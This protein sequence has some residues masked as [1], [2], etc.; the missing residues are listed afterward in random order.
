MNPK[1]VLNKIKTAL[2][3]E[4]KLEAAKLDN[5]TM[6]EAEVFEAGAEIFI[7]TAEDRV[8]LPVGEYVFE[9]G[10][11]LVVAEE[12]IIGEIKEAAAEEEMPVEEAPELEAAPT[13][14]KKVV[15]SVSKEMFFSDDQKKQIQEMFLEFKAELLK[16]LKPKE[17]L[18]K[19]VELEEVKPIKASPEA[20]VDKKELHLYG[21]NQEK[22]LQARVYER[23][24]NY[25]INKN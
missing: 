13:T 11:I 9:D 18:K 8:A 21:Q 25:K 3:M 4:V 12:G 7:V 24:A 1:I 5:G 2:N 16:E 23:I 14:P 17:E 10:K 22:S 15:E 6:V 20:M 19:E